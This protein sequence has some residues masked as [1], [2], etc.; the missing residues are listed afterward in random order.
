M[1][2]GQRRI[3]WAERSMPVLR[4][5]RERFER[6]RPLTGQRIAACLPVSPETAALALVL[7]S[8]GAAVTFCAS[9]P[10]SADDE[11]AASLAAD[12][13][14]AIHAHRDDSAGRRADHLDRVLECRPTI[15]L[16]DGAELVTIL[17]ERRKDLLQ[18]VLGGT[19]ET[20]AGVIRLRA[21]AARGQLRYPIVALNEP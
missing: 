4:I 11:I 9:K 14:I 20:T 18:D 3:A 16:D 6:E 10:L 5:V 8:G 17:H 13:G 19:E 21:L 2:N 7:T 15:T 12:F 1:K